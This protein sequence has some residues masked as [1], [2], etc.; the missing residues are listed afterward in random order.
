[1]P[2]P[3]EAAP[4]VTPA[5]L[6]DEVDEADVSL[7]LRPLTARSVLVSVLLGTHPPRLPTRAL[8][9][10]AELFGV[11]ESAARTA[12]SRLV[13]K[14]E[15]V[16]ENGAYRL[17]GDLLGRQERQD[18]GRSAARR[19]W[20]GEWTMV[21]VTRTGASAG[22]RAA[23]RTALGRARL[24]ELRDGVW[25][26]PDNLD[27]EVDRERTTRSE[28]FADATVGGF[29]PQDGEPGLEAALLWDL[30][31]W[32]TRARGLRREL[33]RLTPGLEAGDDA[34]L[35]RG[36][37]VSAA[38]LRLFQRDPLLPDELLPDDWPGPVLRH[39]YDRF[40][41]AYRTLLRAWFKQHPG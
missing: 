20:N 37:V 3:D 25:V 1:M 23:R 16:A 4:P 27:T 19:S 9:A 5:G 15:L 40:D 11:R 14:G 38:V 26:R 12:L 33:L 22:D 30:D 34:L 29:R 39:D 13:A 7:G 17:V 32:A 31:D 41:V 36:F 24:A 8:I 6:V 28:A 35:A 18:V 10:A 2:S 21:V